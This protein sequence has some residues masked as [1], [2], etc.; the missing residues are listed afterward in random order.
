MKTARYVFF[1]REFFF[2]SGCA[3]CGA[4][5]CSAD[6]AWYG[7]CRHCHDPL[8][9]DPGKKCDCC[10]RPL[11][12]EQNRCLAC[13]RG[14][15]R[16]LDRSIL[17]FPYAGTY[18]KLLS[19]YKFGKNLG[20]GHFFAEKILN[21]LAALKEFPPET[22]A[23]VPVPP[24]PG[25]IWR[26]GWDQ[27]EYLAK[28]LEKG[29]GGLPVNRCLKRLPYKN[30]K[31]LNRENRQTNIRGKIVLKGKA[32]RQAVILDDVC[33]TGSTLDAC[34]AALKAGGAETVYGLCLFYD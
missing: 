32:P 1:L 4:A 25:K 14:D 34:A 17:L 29:R 6:E 26:T 10:G 23:V 24:R 27:V 7:L 33:T 21:S 19:A 3:L 20:L 2:P 31:E 12:S 15:D 22:T 9:P 5:L 18:R 11:I 16:E 28:L 13:R 8:A 30:H